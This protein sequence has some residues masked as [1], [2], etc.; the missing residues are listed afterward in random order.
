MFTVGRILG[1][2]TGFYFLYKT[3]ILVRKKRESL[4]EF[5]LWTGLGLALVLFSLFPKLTDLL[6]RFLGTT[7]GTNA[8]FLL[9]ILLLLFL[10][11]WIFKIVRNLHH[12]VSKLN[13][14]I[15]VFKSRFNNEQKQ[16]KK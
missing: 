7:K 6:S 8:I 13:E 15:S 9:A 1:I 16:D 10:V 4:F 2:L 5:T 12:D 11:F 3:L 14:E